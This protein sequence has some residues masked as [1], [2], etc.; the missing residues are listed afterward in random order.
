MVRDLSPVVVFVYNRP[1]HTLQTLKAL[2]KNRMANDSLLYIYSDGPRLENSLEEEVKIAQVRKVIRSEKWCKEVIIR[3]SPYNKGLA[4]SIVG[5]VTEVIDIHKKIIVL[6]DDVITSS[7]F[8]EYMNDALDLYENEEKIMHIS[9]YMYP[10]TFQLPETL[11][12]NVPYP[13]GGWGTWERAWRYYTNDTE[14]IY[15]RFNTARGWYRF[16]KFGGDFLQGQLARN[17]TGELKSWFIKWHGILLIKNGYTLY[18][19]ISLTNNIGFDASGSNC[20]QIDKYTVPNLA[21]H[22]VVDNIPAKESRIVKKMVKRFYQ[23]PFSLKK[24]VYNELTRYI[25]KEEIQ[26]FKRLFFKDE[27]F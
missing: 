2:S 15:N 13:G 24:M 6:E 14:F 18:P 7:G 3:E 5:G 19:G 20:P 4:D 21:D 27:K 23:G 1:S 11:F 26:K 9:G 10:H 17:L 8:L 25:R 12:F 16:N 22:I